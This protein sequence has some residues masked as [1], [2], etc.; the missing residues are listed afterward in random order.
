MLLIVACHTD[1]NPFQIY[2]NE[3]FTKTNPFIEI[4]RTINEEEVILDKYGL[5]VITYDKDKTI[6]IRALMDLKRHK[7][8]KSQSIGL[9]GNVL[10]SYPNKL[11][12]SN[13]DSQQ[14]V[15]YNLKANR[16]N[17][18]NVGQWQYLTV[19]LFYGNDYVFDI[20]TW[21]PNEKNEM[22][23]VLM[24]FLYTNTVDLVMIKGFAMSP[25]C[26]QMNED[27]KATIGNQKLD[28]IIDPKPTGLEF[29][30]VSNCALFYEAFKFESWEIARPTAGNGNECPD[31]ERVRPA[32][33]SQKDCS[34]QS[35][36]ETSDLSACE[37]QFTEELHQNYHETDTSKTPGE[38]HNHEFIIKNELKYINECFRSSLDLQ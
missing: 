13:F 5:A 2:L 8:R 27:W 29:F 32:C 24:N 19:L 15:K 21:K 26:K 30:S 16:L 33:E 38:A 7:F 17:Y 11:L 1:K 10:N 6:K 9:V 23:D 36:I 31:D 4:A 14:D 34:E 22:N 37:Q 18:L 28:F 20:F 25:N 12:D 3:V 35:V